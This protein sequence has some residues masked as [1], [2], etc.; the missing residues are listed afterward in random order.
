MRTEEKRQRGISAVPGPWTISE[1]KQLC[2]V[3]TDDKVFPTQIQTIM[4]IF[5]KYATGGSFR[6]G[7]ATGTSKV[8]APH[9]AR[10]CAKVL[11]GCRPSSP[12]SEHPQSR[13][14]LA[15]ILNFS[16]PVVHSRK[17]L[18]KENALPGRSGRFRPL[19]VS[20]A[21]K[22]TESDSGADCNCKKYS[23]LY[24]RDLPYYILPILWI[25]T[26]VECEVKEAFPSVGLRS[27]LEFAASGDTVILT[28]G[29]Y[30]GSQNCNIVI[31][32]SDIKIIGLDSPFIDCANTSSRHLTI[33]G[34]N[35]EISGIGFR[36]GNLP[37]FWN[38]SFGN[39]SRQDNLLLSATAYNE[40]RDSRDNAGCL[41]I[42]GR[43]VTIQNAIFINCS[44]AS[45]GGSIAVVSGGGQTHLSNVSISYSKAGSRGGAIV[46]LSSIVKISNSRISSNNALEGGGIYA[47]GN[48]AN[49]A[50]ILLINVNL[51]QNL[52]V[53]SLRRPGDGPDWSGSGG[54]IVIDGENSDL[55]IS[56]TSALVGNRAL[57]LGGCILARSGANVTLLD[58]ATIS[59]N[60]VV[61]AGGAIAVAGSG[62]SFRAISKSI[63]VGNIAQGFSLN[64][65]SNLLNQDSD[66]SYAP[67][68]F[69]VL[70]YGGAVFVAAGASA[71]LEGEM[72]FERNSAN[73]GGAIAVTSMN[74]A[75][76]LQGLMSVST[77]ASTINVS[78]SV[79]FNSNTVFSLSSATSRV[80]RGCG[81]GIYGAGLVS[82]NIAKDTRFGNNTAENFGGAIMSEPGLVCDL[83]RGWD[84]TLF[85]GG[86][87]NSVVVA[88]DSTFMS[89]RAQLGGSIHAVSGSVVLMG[90]ATFH[91]NLATSDGGAIYVQQNSALNISGSVL[92]ILNSARNNGGC[93]FG[94]SSTVIIQEKV[95]FQGSSALA[96]GGALFLSNLLADIFGEVVF[97]GNRAVVGGSIA[98]IAGTLKVGGRVVF[99]NNTAGIAGRLSAPAGGA[100]YA[101]LASVSIFGSVRF[102][103]NVASGHGGAVSLVQGTLVCSGDVL[104]LSNAVMDPI[105]P[106]NPHQG[107]GIYALESTVTVTGRVVFLSNSCQASYGGGIYFRSGVGAIMFLISGDVLFE[108]NYGSLGAAA[109]YAFG[110]TGQIRERVIFNRNVA[111]SLSG[112]GAIFINIVELLVTDD[113]L[114]RNNYALNGGAMFVRGS[115]VVRIGGRTIFNRNEAFRAGA[116]YS[117]NQGVNPV[118]NFISIDG[119]VEFSSNSV[120]FF[121]TTPGVGGAFY[122]LQGELTLSGNTGILDDYIYLLKH[123][124]VFNRKKCHS[125]ATQYFS[126]ILFPAM[127]EGVQY[128]LR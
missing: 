8:L 30:Q 65:S 17:S 111:G 10:D 77:Y 37:G 73:L 15:R 18:Q 67:P 20:V 106:A 2:C 52:A 82:I 88:G 7:S 98:F 50:Q 114:F 110:S 122:V 44:A 62:T 56:G 97:T 101:N 16:T 127:G 84:S 66:K 34:D 80:G 35:V 63:I 9:P 40:I 76:R 11:T 75:L 45:N 100:I 96:N 70:G 93:V 124:I 21:F 68:P 81:G 87:Q 118:G 117:S 116:I 14:S 32:A 108:S 126:T 125:S 120:S 58:S 83:H 42:S 51:S 60:R 33:E 79:S 104:F 119:S 109:F 86:Q 28:P 4:L 47:V 49:R 59:E 112:G 78:G 12:R 72:I 5:E 23:M 128:S 1:G 55:V 92:F 19:N 57:W 115:C 31:K 99:D 36:N 43:D 48:F 29:T 54:G 25:G 53:E 27:I 71:S 123:M 107:G 3:V 69:D 26:M 13:H 38:E 46:V 94:D 39:L 90:R 22:C 6:S 89:N 121:G 41:L 61:F 64:Q 95:S 103:F 85:P 74:L 105:I 91:T 113:V 102:A 24:S